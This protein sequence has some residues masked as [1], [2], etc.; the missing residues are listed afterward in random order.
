MSSLKRQGLWTH[1]S[2]F[3]FSS[4]MLILPRSFLKLRHWE[5]LHRLHF[6]FTFWEGIPRK[7]TSLNSRN[8]QIVTFLT[9]IRA[10]LQF[11]GR[12]GDGE[13]VVQQVSPLAEEEGC[14]REGEACWVTEPW[15]CSDLQLPAALSSHWP[16]FSYQ[17]LP[18]PM[19]G[20]LLFPKVLQSPE[21][22][23]FL[24]R[25][26]QKGCGGDGCPPWHSMTLRNKWADSDGNW[27]RATSAAFSTSLETLCSF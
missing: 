18:S 5:T 23:R 10:E 11:Y 16:P 1:Q 17:F 25:G 26:M 15:I 3:F 22:Q 2:S 12:R 6:Y 27:H 20:S 24:P 13:G 7:G 8:I 14:E 9:L 19:R 4:W 21:Q